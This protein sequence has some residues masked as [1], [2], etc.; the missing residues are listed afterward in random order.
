MDRDYAIFI[1][2]INEIKDK[3]EKENNDSYQKIL[4]AIKD[5]IDA[6]ESVRDLNPKEMEEFKRI[7]Q[8]C[9]TPS[10]IAK[11]KMFMKSS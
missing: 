5:L 8:S 1:Q 2:S 10:L 3:L 9:L 6:I 11:F 4:K 7:V